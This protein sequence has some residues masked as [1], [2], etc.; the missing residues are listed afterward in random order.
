MLLHTDGVTS[1][2]VEITKGTVQLQGQD[3]LL[4]RHE[5]QRELGDVHIPDDTSLLEDGVAYEG[6]SGNPEDEELVFHISV[7]L[8]A[9]DL[10]CKENIM[11]AHSDSIQST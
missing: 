2:Q 10:L 1:Y 7:P 6:P 8:Q 3:I 4:Q 11:S 9:L 5:I